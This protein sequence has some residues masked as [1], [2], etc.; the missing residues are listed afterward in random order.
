MQ[1]YVAVATIIV[2]LVI[3][4]C[5]HEGGTTTKRP[6]TSTETGTDANAAPEAAVS[7]AVPGGAVASPAPAP[8]AA[9]TAPRATVPGPTIAG[10]VAYKKNRTASAIVGAVGGGLHSRAVGAYMESQKQDL[11]KTLHDEIRSGSARVDRLPHNIVRIRVPNRTAFDPDSASI[12]QGFCST[13][14]KV[15]DVVTRYGKTTLTVVGRTESRGSAKHDRKLSEQRALSIAQYLES[16]DVNPVRLA[17]LAKSDADT[18]AANSVAGQK[19][20]HGVEIIV[21]P[22]VAR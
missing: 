4:G 15:A 19:A 1:R 11:Q 21:E 13:M 12:K 14:D 3:S 17:T 9:G 16:K 5:A 10:P 6:I 22:V 18:I 7:S 20:N 8:T 2:S